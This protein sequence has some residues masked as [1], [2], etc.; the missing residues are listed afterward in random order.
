ML[1]MTITDC[2]AIDAKAQSRCPTPTD[3]LFSTTEVISLTEW[4]LTICVKCRFA[5]IHSTLSQS[6]AKRINSVLQSFVI[7][8]IGVCGLTVVDA[9]AY[10]SVIGNVHDALL[11]SGQD[12][13]LAVQKRANHSLDRLDR[14]PHGRQYPR[15]GF[16]GA[17]GER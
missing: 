9:A 7:T 1:H 6:P 13:R 12:V 8:T 3:C 4:K 11:L 2:L 17:W 15:C 5:L 16:E 14:I 10:V